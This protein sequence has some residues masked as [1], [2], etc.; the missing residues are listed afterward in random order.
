MHVLGVCAICAT[1]AA[2]V[3]AACARGICEAHF[4]QRFP[5]F[6]VQCAPGGRLQAPVPAWEHVPPPPIEPST[7]P[8]ENA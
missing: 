5:T 1:P 3:C 7:P 6:C 4:S 2:R 8:L